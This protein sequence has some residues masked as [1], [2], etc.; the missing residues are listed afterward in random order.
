MAAPESHG[1]AARVVVRPLRRRDRSAALARLEGRGRDDLFLIDLVEQ[2]GGTSGDL[3][4]ELVGAWRG[5]ALVGLASQRP[6]LVVESGLEP[7]VREALLGPLADV[8]SGLV[9][10]EARAAGALWNRL[11][12]RGRRALVDRIESG[13]VLLPQDFADRGAPPGVAIRAATAADLEPLVEAA[14]AR[15]REE[16]RPDPFIGDPKGFRRWVAARTGRA[17]VGTAGREVVWVGYADVRHRAGHLLQGVYTWPAFRRRGIAAAGVASLC[18]AAFAAG[19]DHVQL[20]V[21]EG[22]EGALALYERLGFARHAALRTILF[23]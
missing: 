23:V 2:L 5:D 22:N 6:T 10:C 19:A 16:G 11:A 20:S 13:L 21:V 17:Q 18:R 7:A 14:R 3:A 12:I 9:R 8:A 1:R 15:Q 4:P